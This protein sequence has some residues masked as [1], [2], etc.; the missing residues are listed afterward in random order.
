MLSR[1]FPNIDSLIPAWGAFLCIVYWISVPSPMLRQRNDLPCVA[2]QLANETENL[3]IA[4]SHV[5]TVFCVCI[6]L[7]Y[8]LGFL[9]RRLSNRAFLRPAFS[10]V[11]F[12]CAKQGKGGLGPQPLLWECLGSSTVSWRLSFSGRDA[13]E[14]N[15][16]FFNGSL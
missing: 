14:R 6:C 2:S 10:L 12:C 11:I 3:E 13:R 16:I 15:G 1:H 8:Y 9:S 7:T 4:F 5:P